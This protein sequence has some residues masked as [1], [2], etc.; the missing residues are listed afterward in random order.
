[1][2]A[3]TGIG[4]RIRQLFSR[5][6]K[7]QLELKKVFGMLRGEIDYKVVAALLQPVADKRMV[8]GV[9]SLGDAGELLIYAVVTASVMFML[10]IAI[11]AVSTNMNYYA[12]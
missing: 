9:Q 12:G 7:Q 1:M 3:C 6:Y 5:R 11:I 4:V 10:S 2:V 8:Q